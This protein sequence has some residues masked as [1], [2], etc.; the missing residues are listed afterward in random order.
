[1]ATTEFTTV[2]QYIASQPKAVR[3]VLR[4][5]RSA[6]RKA[7]P[8]SSEGISYQ[9]PAVT[10]RGLRVMAYAGWKQHYS[11]YPA[12]ARLV[13]AFKRDLEPYEISKGTIRFP[14][15]NTVPVGLIGRLAK[16]L[17]KEAVRRA[18]LK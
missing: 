8:G 5:V 7:L 10:L 2:S 12:T 3:A 18:A 9:I 6:I 1:M 14:L 15:S 16:F 4:R 17:A 11:I 13:A